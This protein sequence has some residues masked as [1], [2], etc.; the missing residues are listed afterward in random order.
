M[1][2]P[3]S[4]MAQNSAMAQ[5]NLTL[6]EEL[7][8]LEQSITL[9]LQE[10]D[11]NFSRAHRIVTGSILPVVEQ[12][13][14]H[15][16][17]VWEGSKFWKQFF[18]ASANVSLSGYEEP[19]AA[20]DTTDDVTHASA[21][22]DDS[23]SLRADSTLRSATGRPSQFDDDDD[24]GLE[25]SLLSSPSMAK[26]PRNPPRSSFTDDYPS[27]YE[28]LKRE[29]QVDKSEGSGGG[30]DDMS[31]E[32]SGLPE[33]GTVLGAPTTPGKVSQSVLPDMS[34][35]PESSPFAPGSNDQHTRHT[36]YDS[37]NDPL[38]HRM[39]DKTYRIAAT[40]HTARKTHSGGAGTNA[41]TPGTANRTR[42]RLAFDSSPM[43]SPEA[44]APQ[45]RADIFSPVKTPRTP[46][47]SVYQQHRT[48]GKSGGGGLGTASKFTGGAKS[49]GDFITWDS[50]SE[51][52]TEFSP[53]KTMQFHV[54]Q[55]R[56][57]Q[58]PAREASKKIVEDLL[59]T[60][61]GGELTDSNMTEDSPSIVRRNL[62]LD[63]SF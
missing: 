25:D 27:P 4:M 47:V 6:T 13:A 55:S 63:D 2:R 11:H 30:E 35:T 34:M 58:T 22:Y 17:A 45:L 37:N 46:G 9:T 21:A 18:E 49:V 24:E 54:P 44:P 7:E 38:L 33:E 8:K 61:G 10:I 56:L 59:L 1:S 50:D 15:S 28:A 32:A 16:E 42:R 29:L 5:R 3:S 26:T 60:A 14:K 57:M 62:D 48:P 31:S 12:Y 52:E 51:G 40:P 43:S 53:P 41:A 20:D 36:R 39:L 23:P 19:A